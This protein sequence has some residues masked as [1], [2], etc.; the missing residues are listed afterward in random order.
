MLSYFDGFAKAYQPYKGGAWCYEDGC[1]YRGLSLLH[2]ATGEARWLDHLVRL[3]GA[4]VAPDGRLM[5]YDPKDY[6]IDNILSGRALFYL[7]DHAPDPRWLAAADRL[8]AQLARHPRIETGGYWHKKIYPHQ[9]WL[10]GL[11]MGLPFQIEY[12]QRMGRPELVRDAR[13][14]I[15]EALSLTAMPGGLFAHGYDHARAQRWADP[16]TG[17]SPAVWARAMGWLAMAMVDSVALTND[18]GLSARTTALLTRVEALQQPDGGWLQVMDHPALAGNYTESSASAMFTYALRRA[19]RLGL[20][21]A[22]GVEDRGDAFLAARLTGQPPQLQGIVCVAGLGGFSGTYR[23]GTP[24]YYLS[25]KVVADDA[26][27]VGPLMMAKAEALM[28]AT[29]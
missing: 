23:D 10:D 14:Q 28:R 22:S 25:E 12:G 15:L 6:N 4:Q 2:E 1:I 29:V 3:A 24:D 21:A 11:Y 8:A 5:G 9:V 27:G 19:A 26:K 7:A 18:A 17:R 13:D 16:E 20:R